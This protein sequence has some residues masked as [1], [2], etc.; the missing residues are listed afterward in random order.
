[1]AANAE[2]FE[3]GRAPD[4]LL[5]K[6]QTI[7]ARFPTL[8]DSLAMKVVLRDYVPVLAEKGYMLMRRA[9]GA[10][11]TPTGPAVTVFDRSVRF[12]D[13]VA[14][15]ASAA[16]RHFVSIDLRYSAR[17]TLRK[18]L[19]KPPCVFMDV[20]TAGKAAYRFRIPPGMTRGGFL[21]DPLLLP[22]TG[23]LPLYL[24]GGADRVRHFRIMVD[25][26]HRRL[27]QP[28]IRVVVSRQHFARPA[29]SPA[30]KRQL[31]YPM[32]ETIPDKVTH[33]G[34]LGRVVVG[35]KE[36]LLTYPPSEMRFR[37]RPGRHVLTG[38]FGMAPTRDAYRSVNPTLFTVSAAPAEG[39]G[40]EVLLL[41][42]WLRPGQSPRD[43]GFQP[44][45]LSLEAAVP[46]DLILRVRS[47]PGGCGPADCP[48]W[49]GLKIAR[50][51][52]S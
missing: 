46:T 20:L 28:E 6:L 13:V 51:S 40:R 14:V 19:H 34:Q 21:V 24:D 26:Q 31:R 3:S 50:A 48:F 49:T 35:G 45:R 5:L 36:V 15:P 52:G 4:F 42:R 47:G 27:F 18:L 32:F 33:A 41:S 44:I 37:V 11:L 8:D 39:P 16:G 9:P 38:Q 43:I 2:F 1:M 10:G 17:G 7:D 22:T 30:V 12:G 23:L 25:E 29:L